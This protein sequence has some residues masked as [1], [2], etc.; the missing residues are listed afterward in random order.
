MTQHVVFTLLFAKLSGVFNHKPGTFY[1]YIEHDT[2]IIYLYMYSMG[3]RSCLM[4][5]CIKKVCSFEEKECAYISLSPHNTAI[6][7][8]DMVNVLK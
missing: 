6:A 5:E 4:F 7:F 1:N 2:K 3:H 8:H